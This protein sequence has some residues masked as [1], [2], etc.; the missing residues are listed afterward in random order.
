[1]LLNE[2][3]ANLFHEQQVL[4]KH[5]NDLQFFMNNLKPLSNLD[6][7]TKDEMDQFL[8]EAFECHKVCY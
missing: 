5:F 4:R 8:L 2:W 7:D 3:L 6:G 1:M